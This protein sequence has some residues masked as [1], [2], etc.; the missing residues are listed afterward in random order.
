[1]ILVDHMPGNPLA[2][3]TYQAIG[4]SDAAEIFVFISGITCGIVYSRAL[5]RRGLSAGES[6]MS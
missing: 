6:H 2:K 1:M 3:F 5:A 4:F